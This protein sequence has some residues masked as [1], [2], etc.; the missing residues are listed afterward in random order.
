[1]R[2]VLI[3]ILL[4]SGVWA[5]GG[6]AA[7]PRLEVA[8]RV[9]DAGDIQRGVTLRHEFVLKNTG[10]AELSVDAKPG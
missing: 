3:A 9:H 10:T 1:M 5:A 8:E 4:A 2:A 6:D 7:A